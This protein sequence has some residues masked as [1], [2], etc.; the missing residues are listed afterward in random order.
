MIKT[1]QYEYRDPTGTWHGE[2]T[3]VESEPNQFYDPTKKNSTEETLTIVFQ[4]TNIEDPEDQIVHSQ[5]FI[6]PLLGGKGL[7]QQLVT[8]LGIGVA[9]GDNF[10]EDVL[11]GQQMDVGI[12]LNPKGYATV[13][14]VSASTRKK[15]AT[16]SEEARKAISKKPAPAPVADEVADNLPWE[17]DENA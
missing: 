11:V 17:T 12:S 15:A 7:L 5:R 4:L 9:P 8:L 2:I 6:A 16:K 10:N 13:D 1:T 3:E 14:Y